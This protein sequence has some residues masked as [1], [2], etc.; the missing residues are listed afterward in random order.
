MK[1]SFSNII[2]FFSFLITQVLLTNFINFGPLLFISVYPLFIL[3]FPT[4]TSPV[5]MLLWSFALG[6]GVDYFTDSILGLNAAAA[7]FLAF[8]QP[9][10]FKLVCRKGELENQIRPG[11]TELGLSRFLTFI[12]IGLTIHHIAITLLENFSFAFQ[13][14]SL[15]RIVLSLLV[16]TFLILLIE[17]GIFY[18]NW[19]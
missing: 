6:L 1:N 17:F 10:I 3:T 7:V 4:N 11:L 14:H 5:N 16:N 8:V 18:K 15:V 13:F 2:L 12:A 19:R 9:L